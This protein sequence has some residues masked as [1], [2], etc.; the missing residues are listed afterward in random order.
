ML[1]APRRFRSDLLLQIG[2]PFVSPDRTPRA[3]PAAR[4]AC[5]S[6]G[7]AWA[8]AVATFRGRPKSTGANRY[9]LLCCAVA[10]GNQ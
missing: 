8:L 2:F 7:S 3:A 9:A 10:S 5:A 4:P 6:L 1:Y